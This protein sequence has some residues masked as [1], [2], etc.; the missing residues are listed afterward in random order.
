MTSLFTQSHLICPGTPL[1]VYISLADPAFG[2]PS[3][4][5]ILLGVDVFVDI[6]RHGRWTGSLGSPVALETEFGWVLSGSTAPSTLTEDQ[7][8]LHVMAL[9]TAITTCG[10]DILRKFWEIEESPVNLPALSMEE[11]A[12]VRHF[13]A[14]HRRTEEGRFEVPLPRRSDVKP[15]GESRSQALR[16]FLALERSP[17]H[18]GCFQEVNTV[19]QEYFYLGHAQEVPNQDLDKD[20]CKVF[21]L[22]MHVVY[23]S[24][25]TTTKVRPVFD[26]SAK[27]STGESLND[28]LLVGPTVH[29]LLIDVLLQFRWHRIAL[30]ADVSKMYR[31][32]ELVKSDQDFHHFVWRSEPDGSLKDYQMTRATFGVSASCFAAN[33]AVKQNAIDLSHVYPL[34]AEAVEK[35]FYVDDG[36]TGADDTKRA[37]T[38]HGQLCDLFSHG[39]FV[40]RKWN[41]SDPTVLQ[42]IPPDLR[43]SK[44]VL[45]ICD[46]NGCTKTLGLEWNTT[47]DTFHLTISKFPQ[48]ERVTKRLLASDVAKVY[49]ILGWYSPVTVT[50]K[51]LLQRIWELRVDWEILCLIT[52]K[53]SGLSGDPSY[54][55]SLPSQ[56][57]VARS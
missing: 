5:D 52:S 3:H 48:S 1:L 8:N 18:K 28:T 47:T 50:M 31:A 13:E 42:A 14:N 12:V 21:Y 40:L 56:Y 4:I 36:L 30:T 17:N 32:V 25:S 24:S 26:A 45:P 54:Q 16:R 22:P 49:D 33:M 34:A 39:D 51:I 23:K 35:S 7:V 53:M 57:P 27:S 9:H 55:F 11:R 43:D 15:I 38:L 41:S 6:L 2:Q 29:P 46:S 19:I 20:P 44:E 10:D 37:T